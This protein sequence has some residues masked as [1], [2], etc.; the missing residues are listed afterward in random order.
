MPT[1]KKTLDIEN[2][3]KPSQED[4]TRFDAIEDRSID[5]ADI[6][7]LGDNFFRK[8]KKKRAS[9]RASMQTWCNGSKR[10][11]RAIKPK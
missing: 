5:Y 4:L 11:V 1:V 2:P 3:P 8:A 7:E 6:P 9:P 10:R